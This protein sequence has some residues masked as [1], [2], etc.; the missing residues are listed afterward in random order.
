MRFH[1]DT[2]SA[3]ADDR[4]S[5]FDVRNEAEAS[6][7]LGFGPWGM[8]AKVKNTI[9]YVSTQRTQTTEEMNTDL[10]LSSSV[11]LVFKTDYLPL[12]RLAGQGQVDRIRVNTLNPDAEL[13]A[14]TEERRARR[15][16][17]ATAERTRASDL[18]TR[19]TPQAPPPPAARPAEPA[20]PQAPQ[21]GQPGAPGGTTQTLPPQ[22]GSQPQQ[23]QAQPRPAGPPGPAGTGQPPPQQPARPAEPAQRTAPQ[24][25]PPGPPPRPGPNPP[26][27]PAA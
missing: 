13:R 17:Q 12:D 25:G 8:D 16:S 19:L 4:G 23:P 20:R 27:R 18:N 26:P 3:A 2:R 24:A 21:T 7:R 15:E 10:D 11:E 14:A 22:P 5:T 6:G 9:G 1:I